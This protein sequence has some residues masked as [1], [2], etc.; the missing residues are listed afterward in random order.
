M[1]LSSSECSSDSGSSIKN[2]ST[3]NISASDEDGMRL[4]H[5]SKQNDIYV[6]V[7]KV[8]RKIIT[9]DGVVQLLYKLGK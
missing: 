4:H 1:G 9:G 3:S 8:M 5:D 6:P 2:S 7:N